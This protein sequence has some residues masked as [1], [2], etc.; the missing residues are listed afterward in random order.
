MSFLSVL[1]AIGLAFEKGLTWAVKYAMPVASLVSLLF[2]AAAPAAVG[3][4][5]AVDLI[6]K[7]V[8]SVE[9]KYAASGV[10][11]GTGTQK[12][13]EVLTLTE[14]AVTTLLKQE[15]ITADTT[16]ITNIVNAV[17]ALLNVQM[18][19]AELSAK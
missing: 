8:L 17:V 9:Q 18:A 3:V 4:V 16:F 7:A 11:S 15:G 10:S 19:S 2:P 12:L 6:Q 5:N 13:A 14:D 1:K